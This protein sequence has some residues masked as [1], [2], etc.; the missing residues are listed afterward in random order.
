MRNKSDPTAV[1]PGS[2]AAAAA[3]A[4]PFYDAEELAHQYETLTGQQEGML[5]E[6]RALMHDLQVA[7]D[8]AR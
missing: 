4:V 6:R 3:R 2:G 7:E 5:K 1:K 8:E